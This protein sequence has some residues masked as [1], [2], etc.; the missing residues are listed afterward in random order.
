M[1]KQ[2][3]RRARRPKEAEGRYRGGEKEEGATMKEEGRRAV[4]EDDEATPGRAKR[5]KEAKGSYPGDATRD[6]KPDGYRPVTAYR[7]VAGK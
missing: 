5:P 7:R 4:G 1:T 3:R 2:L 6:R